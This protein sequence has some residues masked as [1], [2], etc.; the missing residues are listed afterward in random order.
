MGDDM[1]SRIPKERRPVEVKIR[2]ESV[3]ALT[4]YGRV[5]IAF[6]VE[7]RFRVDPMDDGLG[8]LL[9]REEKVEPPYLKDYDDHREEGPTR[10]AK[11]WD[12]SNWGILSAYDQDTRVGGAVI[13]CDTEGVDMLEGRKDIAALWDI[14]VQP[15]VR[16]QGVGAKLFQRAVDWS[17]NKGCR[18]LKVETQNIN[19][20]A[21]RFYLRQGCELGAVN[22]FA[23]HELP[24]EVQLIWY[25]RLG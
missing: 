14:R 2:E 21:C 18:L 23:Y 19:V 9:L 7:M 16:G 5:S 25:R 11:R 3:D 22:R 15:E 1:S 6:Q 10:W 12:I 13:A 4:D 20:A 8:G 24:E 17:K